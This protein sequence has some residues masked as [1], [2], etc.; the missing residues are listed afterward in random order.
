VLSVTAPACARRRAPA[1]ADLQPP[2]HGTFAKTP[3]SAAGTGVANSPGV[4]DRPLTKAEAAERKLRSKARETTGGVPWARCGNLALG[5]WLQISAFV[6]PRT[7]HSR[8]SAWLPGLMISIVALLSMGAPPMRWLNG[9]L[10]LWL[11]AWTF[12]ATGNEWLSFASGVA[13]A[14]LVLVLS[15]IPSDSAATD[16]RD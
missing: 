14:V 10:A 13:T 7:D 16:F 9:F 2:K 15:T 12:A 1:G 8:V 3:P 4:E 11:L 6:W 5:L